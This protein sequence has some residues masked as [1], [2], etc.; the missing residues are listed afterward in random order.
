MKE[1]REPLQAEE[2][3]SRDALISRRAL[4][5]G[6][7]SVLGGA[8]LAG[9]PEVADSQQTAKADAPLPKVADDPTKAPGTPTSPVGARSPFVKPVRAPVGEI[10]GSSFTPLEDLT[11][12]ITPSD[13]HFERH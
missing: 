1:P 11:G 9:L 8:L 12:T 5:A 7:G 2:D 13:L 10:T 3:A 6:A 4:L